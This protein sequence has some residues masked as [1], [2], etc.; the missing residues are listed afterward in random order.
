MN[1]LLQ[2]VTTSNIH[3]LT[4]FRPSQVTVSYAQS[5]QS[6]TV[7]T[8]RCL[9]KASNGGL[10]LFYGFPKYPRSQ[11]QSSNCNSSHNMSHNSPLAHWFTKVKVMLWLTVS[12]PVSMSW[13]RIHS[14]TCDQILFSVWKLL[15]VSVGRRLWREVGSVSCQSL[16]AVFSPLSKFNIIYILHVYTI[17]TRT[18]SSIY[19]AYEISARTA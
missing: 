15:C 11:L 18:L 7:F 17:H 14:G 10:Y 9:L 19:L 8:S 6:V 5:S 16:S 1:E 13:C 12:Q 4:V 2:L 3:D